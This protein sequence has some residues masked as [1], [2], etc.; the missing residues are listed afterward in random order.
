MS[1]PDSLARLHARAFAPTGRGWSAAEFAYLIDAPHCCLRHETYGFALSR[2]IAGEAELLTLATDPEHRR[3]GIAARLLAA[4]ESAAM[5]MGADRQFLEVA[6]DNPAA[7]A[8][9]SAFGYAEIARRAGYYARPGGTPVDAL[10][11]SKELTP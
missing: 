2:V 3:Q 10:V 11:L 9:Y 6:A 1:L 5:D 7:R 4:V 8:L